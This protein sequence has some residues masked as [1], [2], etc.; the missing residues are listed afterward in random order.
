MTFP[1]T[2]VLAPLLKEL[3]QMHRHLCPRQVLGIRMG[4]FGLRQM[5]LIESDYQPRYQNKRKQLLCIMESDGC[6]AD[7]VAVATDCFVG[8]RTLRVLD[9]GKM[10]CTLVDTHTEKM[11]RI[12]PHP[13]ARQLAHQYAPNSASRWHTYLDGYQIIPD[14]LLLITQDVI[15]TQSISEILSRPGIRVNCAQCGEEIVNQREVIVNGRMLCRSC[16]G[17]SYFKKAEWN[18]E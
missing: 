13:N 14:H 12:I 5:G 8:N 6:G 16:A 18:A 3:S 4:L 2:A 15:L 7:G 17:D 9:Y 11:L 10:A 1:N